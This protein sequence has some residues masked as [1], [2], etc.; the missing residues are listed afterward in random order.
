MPDL[1][2]LPPELLLNILQ[3]LPVQCLNGMMKLS[4]EWRTFFT[5]NEAAIYRNAALVHHFVPSIDISLE[6]AK[7]LYAGHLLENVGNWRSFCCHLFLLQRNWAGRGTATIKTFNS[8]TR[9][10]HRLKVDERNGI[11]LT[12]HSQGGLRVSDLETDNI[13]WGLPETYVRSWAHCEYSNGFLIFDRF[14]E[15]KEVWRLKNEYD[16]VAA[17]MVS[18]A[19][20]VIQRQ[21]GD[22]VTASHPTTDG[23]GHFKPWALLN[24]PEWGRAFRFVYPTLLVASMTK[25]YLYDVVYGRLVQT[26]EHSPDGNIEDINYVEL[27][28]QYVFICTADH[29]RIYSRKNGQS[30][31]RIPSLDLPS[32]GCFSLD[33]SVFDFDGKPYKPTIIPVSLHPA[34]PERSLRRSEFIGVHVCGPHLVGLLSHN[35]VVFVRDYETAITSGVPLS[36]LTLE[37]TL[38]HPNESIGESVYVAYEHGH[39]GVV[40]TSGVFVFT[41][42]PEYHGLSKIPSQTLEPDTNTSGPDTKLIKLDQTAFPHLVAC[43]ILPFGDDHLLRRVSCLQMS[44]SKLYFT[45]DPQAIRKNESAKRRADDEVENTEPQAGPSTSRSPRSIVPVAQQQ[46]QAGPPED[47]MIEWNNTEYMTLDEPPVIV[48]LDDE[49][50]DEEVDSDTIDYEME[51]ED[52]TDEDEDEDDDNAVPWLHVP[53]LRASVLSTFL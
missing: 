26:I 47:D 9:N 22:L 35:S 21:V 17:E 12:T 42:E 18:N 31:L 27:N 19:P 50:I 7:C 46:A 51:M 29:L 28:D 4:R 43:R 33:H 1:N 39:V 20:D 38:R 11:L 37:I 13:L 34:T 23:R 52:D 3:Y 8:P 24:T 16:E 10:V 49:D 32:A 53:A 15:F 44:D 2:S 5:A 48:P 30:V 41:V 40:T 25:S 45:Y 14:G 36:N 6:D